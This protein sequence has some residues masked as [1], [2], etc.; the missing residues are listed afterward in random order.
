MRLAGRLGTAASDPGAAPAAHGCIRQPA[1]RRRIRQ[2][3]VSSQCARESPAR[4]TSVDHPNRLRPKPNGLL[5]EKAPARTSQALRL[6]RSNKWAGIEGLSAMLI[7]HTGRLR[8]R[9]RPRSKHRQ[10]LQSHACADL[11]CFVP[12]LIKSRKPL[13]ADCGIKCPNMDTLRGDVAQYS[14]CQPTVDI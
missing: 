10:K 11:V 8:L 12:H 5:T 2:R 13:W 7:E 14:H 9:S 1:A 6:A 3:R 4:G